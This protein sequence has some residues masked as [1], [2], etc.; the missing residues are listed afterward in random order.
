[1]SYLSL[2]P[3][4]SLSLSPFLSVSVSLSLSG[5][6]LT[7]LMFIRQS[8]SFPRLPGPPPTPW[9]SVVRVWSRGIC[10]L[11]WSWCSFQVNDSIDLEGYHTEPEPLQANDPIWTTRFALDI[12]LLHM[13]NNNALLLTVP[14]LVG[15]P[16]RSG[17]VHVRHS[18]WTA[19][20][21]SICG[22]TGTVRLE[23]FHSLNGKVNAGEP[24]WI[25][26]GKGSWMERRE[27]FNWAA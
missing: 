8:I 2:S 9:A 7:G 1:M 10:S 3:S 20:I 12:R 6:P 4:L 16:S 27:H 21:R 19:D 23:Q 24:L 15:P 22:C 17:Q 5:C 18:G 14:A 11:S 26:E 25:A 13:H